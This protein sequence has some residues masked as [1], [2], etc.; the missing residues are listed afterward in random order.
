MLTDIPAFSVLQK[1]QTHPETREAIH[2]FV[3]PLKI[4]T[5]IYTLALPTRILY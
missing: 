2:R 5:N 1:V 3:Q 4:S